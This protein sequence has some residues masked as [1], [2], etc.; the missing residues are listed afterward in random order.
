MANA[1]EI[2]KDKQH[3]K[4]YRHYLDRCRYRDPH[5]KALVYCLG[6]DGNTRGHIHDIYDFHTG[7]IKTECLHE[8]WQTDSS[9]KVVRLAFNLY[10][11][12]TVSVYDYGSQG[13]QL[14][15]C[16]HYSAAEIMCCEYVKYFLEAV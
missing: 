4:F 13:G 16:R 7:C 12:R 9:K 5:H 15:E 11:D 1:E 10:T 2:Y 6:I 3:E 14:W 8:G